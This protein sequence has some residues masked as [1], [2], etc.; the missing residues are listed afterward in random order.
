MYTLG[1]RRDFIARHY[2]VGGD[3]GAENIE[4]AHR[5]RLELVLEAASL[6]HHG[7]L[8]DIVAVEQHLDQVVA[9][10][11]DQT[12]NALAAFAGLNPSI[13]RLATVLHERFRERLAQVGLVALSVTIW[14]DE[15]AWTSYRDTF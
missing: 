7:F 5:Y 1:V 10:F 13:E 14:E 11:R 2:L 6:D 12:L 8:V 4:H 3:W 9:D 15:I